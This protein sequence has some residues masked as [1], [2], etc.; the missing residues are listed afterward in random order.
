MRD[1]SQTPK[2]AIAYVQVKAYYVL[3]VCLSACLFLF[4]HR[5][6]RSIFRE[7]FFVSGDSDFLISS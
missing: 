5:L 4:S 7:M 3:F 1:A 6:D 2:I